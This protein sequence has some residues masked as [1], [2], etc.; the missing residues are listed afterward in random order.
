MASH[1]GIYLNPDG[2]INKIVIPHYENDDHLSTEGDFAAHDSPELLRVTVEKSFL[3][4]HPPIQIDGKSIYHEL[5]KEIVAEVAIADRL[6][7]EA[8]QDKIDQVETIL[9]QVPVEE[10]PIEAAATLEMGMW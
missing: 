5:T 3:D 8:L 10:E 4:T 2:T 1:I 9:K 7:A 6:V